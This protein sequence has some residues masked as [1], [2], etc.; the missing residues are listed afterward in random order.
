M[1]L[2]LIKYNI[3]LLFSDLE[4]SAFDAVNYFIILTALV[5]IIYAFAKGAKKG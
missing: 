4:N 5:F 3:R 1:L 2:L